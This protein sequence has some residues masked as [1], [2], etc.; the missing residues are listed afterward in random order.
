MQIQTRILLF[1]FLFISGHKLYG[2]EDLLTGRVFSPEI[3]PSKFNI[4]AYERQSGDLQ[5]IYLYNTVTNISA[6]VKV[7]MDQGGEDRNL[8]FL[9]S[10]FVESELPSQYAGLLDWRPVLDY[11]GRQ[12]FVFVSSSST[13]IDL[14]LSY[15]DQYGNQA[16]NVI[17]LH[18]DGTD[19]LPKWSPDGTRIVFVSEGDGG[20]DLF[21]ADNMHEVIKNEDSTLFFPYKITSNPE[22]DTYP[23]WSPDGKYIAYQASENERSAIHLLHVDDIGQNQTAESINLTP[24][25][26]PFDEYKPSWS[27]EGT[28]VA[29]Y[30]SQRGSFDEDSNNLK[31]DIGITQVKKNINSDRVEKGVVRRG[32][33]RRFA[34]NIVPNRESGPTWMPYQSNK[35]PLS[36]IYVAKSVSDSI[37]YSA[38]TSDE[39][40]PAMLGDLEKWLQERKHTR[41]MNFK[42]IF[43]HDIVVSLVPKGMQFAL[44]AQKGNGNGLYTGLSYSENE[45]IKT[46]G[47]IPTMNE[48]FIPQEKSKKVAFWRSAIFPGLGQS[49][50]KQKTRAILFYASFTLSVVQTLLSQNDLSKSIDS[51]EDERAKY[52]AIRQNSGDFSGAFSNWDNAYDDVKSKVGKRNL[53]S[54]ISVGIWALNLVDSSRNFPIRGQS[55][56]DFNDGLVSFNAP[57]FRSEQ[58]GSEQ[59]FFLEARL[60][61]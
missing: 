8:D 36:I 13:D 3:C 50:K 15:I 16:A 24:E 46:P 32:Y 12:W 7:P 60:G 6:P 14:Y 17:A 43:N 54:W 39:N 35:Y 20:G 56:I 27:P 18:H 44:I 9:E 51:Y 52:L 22:S 10:L 5:Q 38:R 55:P 37:A 26:A 1:I 61:F 58:R 49:Y 45:I 40:N 30:V 23:V 31:Q 42:T 41:Q 48:I 21:V 19:I 53:W 28:Y 29:F 34:E 47:K 33:S 25:L 2:Q 4:I 57:V 11:K 59:L